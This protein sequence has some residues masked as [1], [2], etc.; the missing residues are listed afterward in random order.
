MTE[1]RRAEVGFF[2]D[3]SGVVR[4]ASDQEAVAAATEDERGR[5]GMTE[6]DFTYEN[7]AIIGSH[8]KDV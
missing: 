1:I 5:H 3:C 2:A 8:I 7:V 6:A 4:G